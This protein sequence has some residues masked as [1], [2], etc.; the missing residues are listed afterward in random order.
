ML[1]WLKLIGVSLLI[2]ANA[3]LADALP[4]VEGPWSD[5]AVV[6]RGEPIRLSGTAMSSTT[7][8]VDFAGEAVEVV[9][10]RDGR[11]AAEISPQ[12]AGG[13]F[14]LTISDEEGS[15]GYEDI[16][17][18]DVLLCA[19][20]SN[21]EFP[22]YR[23][24]Y[25]DSVLEASPDPH[26]RLLTIPKGAEVEVQ[27]GFSGQ[28]AWTGAGP[29]TVK[30]FS[31]V[32][33]FTGAGLRKERDV[34]VGLINASWG[35]SQIE[36]WLPAGRLAEAGGFAG[37]L[38]QLDLYKTDR[39]AAM[40]AF[41]KQWEA[42]WVEAYGTE[43][44]VGSQDRPGW[45]AAPDEMVDWKTYGDPQARNHLGRVWYTRSFTL[46]AEQAGQTGDLSLGLFDDADATW[47]NGRFLGSTFSWTD[48][49]RYDVPAGL[50][51]A[52]ENT[53]TIN[54]L[55]TYGQGG[56]LGPAEVVELQLDSGATVPLAGDWHY[57][58]VEKQLPGG[59]TP[60]WGSV[61]GYTTIHN[62]M[63][64]PLGNIG[65][66]VAIWYQGES[67]TDRADSYEGLLRQLT[68]AWREQF[69]G[70]LPV[71]VVQLPEFG[72]MPETPSPS[73]WADLREA[74]RRAAVAEDRTGL[75]VALG[76]GD[77]TD[78]H[79][80]NKLLVAQRILPVLQSVSGADNGPEDGVFPAVTGHSS[81]TVTLELPEASYRV[82]G[83][84]HPIAFELCDEAQACVW[85]EA[86]MEGRTIT[87]PV[88]SAMNVREVR[89][90]WG[91]APVC[92]LFTQDDVPVTPFRLA[93]D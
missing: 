18:G 7:V 59:P 92:N 27:H 64:A 78:I 4:T 91:D 87:L 63:I 48:H 54:V 21:M 1:S 26:L 58:V 34:P 50:L 71:V 30:D 41:G 22:V 52:G 93:L 81:E 84:D 44:W 35:G 40:A 53:I 3:G 24:L 25:P 88:P 42:W 33:Y 86:R 73:G 16:L 76:A 90:C 74:Q 20:Q 85:A 13:P 5:H 46:T 37:E 38:T 62:A 14:T 12:P 15:L 29:E 47:L 23:A 8:A 83:A 36:A 72:G 39:A 43:P 79:P 51:K 17:V 55:N 56:M 45:K 28:A 9:A 61:S 49:R 2:G 31:A 89:Y 6:Q 75:A 60:A 70:D 67:N 57:R 11:W 66:Y 10:G 19:G 32:C 82:I 68:K 65:L 69:A 80:P 77:R